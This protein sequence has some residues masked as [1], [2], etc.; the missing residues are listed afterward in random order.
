MFVL[1]KFKD[2]WLIVV[3]LKLLI[4][5]VVCLRFVKEIL[6]YL[7]KWFIFLSNVVLVN[8]LDFI[9]LFKVLSLFFVELFVVIVMLIG[10]FILCVIFVI[11]LLSEVI[12]FDLINFFCMV[13]NLDKVIL[14]V[15]VCFVICCFNNWLVCLS[16][17][18]VC[19]FFW[20]DSVLLYKFVNVLIN[21]Y[22]F[23]F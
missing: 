17:V 20:V 4:S 1:S 7:F 10:V 6:K 22:L 13:V 5:F 14:S 16:F 15:W 23:L 3:C 12:F 2:D 11:R 8:V 19:L 18:L 21:E 9:N